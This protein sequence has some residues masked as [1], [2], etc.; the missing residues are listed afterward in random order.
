MA[1]DPED[2]EEIVIP[3]AFGAELPAMLPVRGPDGE[4]VEGAAARLVRDEAGIV[5]TITW[6]ERGLAVSARIP[7]PPP[8][9]GDEAST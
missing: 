9:P 8:D 7:D 1:G 5:V 3:G 2:R 6:P 4:I